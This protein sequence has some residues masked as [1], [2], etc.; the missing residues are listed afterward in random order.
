MN[1]HSQGPDLHKTP[2]HQVWPKK[3]KNSVIVINKINKNKMNDFLKILSKDYFDQSV[4]KIFWINDIL[5]FVFFLFCLELIAFFQ[6]GIF[7]NR[8]FMFYMR[9]FKTRQHEYANK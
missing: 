3:K 1:R 7:T 2:K 5:F 4:G 8:L 6:N 9:V